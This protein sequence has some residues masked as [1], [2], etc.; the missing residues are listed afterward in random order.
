V[1]S[2]KA[3]NAKVKAMIEEQAKSAAAQES[4]EKPDAEVIAVDFGAKS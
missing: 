2:C 3:T 4:A 1:S